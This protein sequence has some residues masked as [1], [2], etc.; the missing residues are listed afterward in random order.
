ML[1]SPRETLEYASGIFLLGYYCKDIDAMNF[2][3]DIYT[4]FQADSRD[5]LDFGLSARFSVLDDILFKAVGEINFDELI[6]YDIDFNIFEICK[7]IKSQV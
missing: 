2:G 4:K 6:Q 5:L 1:D 7:F 3:F